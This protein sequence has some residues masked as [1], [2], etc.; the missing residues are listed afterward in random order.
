[1][2]LSIRHAAVT[3]LGLVLVAAASRASQT[4]EA[5]LLV[6]P[7]QLAREL[8]D[9]ALVILQIGPKDDYDAGH[10]EGARFVQFRD[11]AA[12]D[13]A[14]QRALELPAESELRGRLER[15]G[16][17]DGS[18]IVVVSGADRTNGDVWVSPATRLVWTLQAAG[19][20]DRTRLLDGGLPAWRRAGLP[21]TTAVPAP[22]TGRLTVAADRSVVVDHTWM[23]SRLRAPGVRIIDGRAPMFF[24]GPGMPE[25]NHG[26]GHL[27]GA[28]NVP[29]NTLT[30]DSSVFL[31]LAELRRKF[32]AAG[33]QPGDTIAAYCHIGQQATVVLFSARLLGHPVRLY[34]GSMDDWEK[35][36]LPL[37][38]PTAPKKPGSAGEPR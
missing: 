21:L 17:G 33:V 6:T 9:P 1:M 19:L 8:N 24:E 34:D 3:T 23:Q 20:A 30:N 22:R 16:I 15:L 37:E 26:A 31:P 14:T 27:P 13:S 29:F 25:H 5:A 2:S 38:N 4:R 28:A 32:A 18:R 35:R 12:P 11:I 36:K 10:I 7:P